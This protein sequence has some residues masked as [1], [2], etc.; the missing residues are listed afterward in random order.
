MP[1]VL[2]MSHLEVHFLPEQDR[3]EAYW[4]ERDI[5]MDEPTFRNH[6]EQFARLF[7]VYPVPAFLVD[8]RLSSIAMSIQLQEWH[9]TQI[10]P[11]YIA[12]GVKKIAFVMTEKFMTALSVE[13]TFQEPR[14]QELEVA[15][16][17]ERTEARI[18]LEA[19][20]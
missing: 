20:S 19:A 7:E 1:L 10:V 3:I 15:Y 8:N 5:P 16:F 11:R 12:A 18:W 2:E 9:D 17:S 13:Q 4:I 6:I 14:A